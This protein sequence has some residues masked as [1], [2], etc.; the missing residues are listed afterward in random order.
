MSLGLVVLRPGARLPIIRRGQEAT[1]L[2][3]GRGE[4]E[5]WRTLGEVHE[6]IR[7]QRGSEAGGWRIGCRPVTV[8]PLVSL[9]NVLMF[10]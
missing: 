3:S 7:M 4:L 6:Y 8:W 5:D 9:C 2:E 10:Y 1:E